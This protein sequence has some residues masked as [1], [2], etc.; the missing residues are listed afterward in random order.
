MVKGGRTPVVITDA[1][2]DAYFK[3][4]VQKWKQSGAFKAPSGYDPMRSEYLISLSSLEDGYT[5]HDHVS[6]RDRML[7]MGFDLKTNKFWKS[8]YSFAPHFYSNLN[9]KLVSYH[10]DKD[11]KGEGTGGVLIDSPFVVPQIHDD[12]S[13]RNKIYGAKVRSN[14]CVSANA[15]NSKTKEFNVVVLDS[16]NRWEANL[17]TP[18]GSS[19]IPFRKFKGYNDK[20]YGTIPGNTSL[21]AEERKSQIT[22]ST[23]KTMPY[24]FDDR[25]LPSSGQVIQTQFLGPRSFVFV[26]ENGDDYNSSYSTGIKYMEF[27][28]IM[29][30][31][32]S[33]FTAPLALGKN[34]MLY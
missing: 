22:K 1:N 13:N 18:N 29:S 14:I 26:D 27:T 6:A 33:A 25:L 21:A 3:S 32:S 20:Y 5:Y 30:K 8:R 19:A 9:G 2:V 12:T 23:I 31:S 34:S 15:N 4:E 28:I 17:Y 24:A 11:I 10:S 7:T 16:D